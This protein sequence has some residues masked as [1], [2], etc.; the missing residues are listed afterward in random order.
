MHTFEAH[1]EQLLAL[2]G[3]LAAAAEAASVSQTAW[4]VICDETAMV[5]A[6]DRTRREPGLLVLRRFG[7]I[8]TDAMKPALHRA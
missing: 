2:C 8:R 3:G 1:D 6:D 5:F 4:R 7:H